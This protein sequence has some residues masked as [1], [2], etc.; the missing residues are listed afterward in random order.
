MPKIQKLTNY[1]LLI[2]GALTALSGIFNTALD[3]YD[4]IKEEAGGTDE[5]AMEEP[6]TYDGPVVPNEDVLEENAG[7]TDPHVQ[8]VQQM[9]MPVTGSSLAPKKEKTATLIWI[10]ASIV[11]LLSIGLGWF[12][13]KKHIKIT[14][15]E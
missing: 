6:M 2:G 9:K 12:L 11:G 14:T 5:A 15:K 4:R 10:V 1:L 3:M 13:H 8:Q 7:D